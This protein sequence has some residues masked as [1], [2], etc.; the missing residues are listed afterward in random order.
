MKGWSGGGMK[1]GCG[2]GS[3]GVGGWLVEQKV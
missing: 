2:R 3:E 1:E